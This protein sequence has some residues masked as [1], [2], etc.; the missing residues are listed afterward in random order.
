MT[1]RRFVMGVASA[2]GLVALA[3]CGSSSPSATSSGAA[4][5]NNTTAATTTSSSSQSSA[6]GGATLT[7]CAAVTQS[8]AVSI[9]GD[10]AITQSNSLQ[11]GGCLYTDPG[12]PLAA[13]NGVL[14]YVLP[15]PAINPQALQAALTQKVNGGANNLQPISGIGDL[16]YATSNQ[17]G[18]A[19][20]FA[21]G[22]QVV[23]ISGSSKTRSGADIL[24]TVKSVATRDAGQM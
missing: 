23:I 18:G 19:V 15:V 22:S 11:G 12:Q 9:T 14:V 21:K 3:A 5:S 7:A 4:S 10:Q 6:G 13:G 20:V 2:M 24:S 1:S 17:N 8:D 16:A